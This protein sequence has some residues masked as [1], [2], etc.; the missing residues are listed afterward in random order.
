MT[1]DTMQAELP[2]RNR[3]GRGSVALIDAVAPLELSAE[4][5]G[6]RVLRAAAQGMIEAVFERACTVALS[7][8]GSIAL[9]A[10]SCGNHPRGVRLTCSPR[11][12]RIVRVGMRVRIS[13]ARIAIDEGAVAVLLQG[14][15]TWAPALRPGSLAAHAHAIASLSTTE[16]LLRERAVRSESAFLAVTLGADRSAGPL[17]KVVAEFLPRLCTAWAAADRLQVV[18]AVAR[19]IGL[20]PGLT[21]AG[22]DF[23][24]GWLA[25]MALTACSS[26]QREFLNLV[27]ADLEP[28]RSA[29]T[30]TSREYLDDARALLFSERLCDLAVAITACA[31]VE[32]LAE[33]V[34]AQLAV[35]A[36][37][38]ADAAAGLIAALHLS[39]HGVRAAHS[40]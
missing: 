3:A 27:C 15:Q 2:V 5:I 18:A 9:L 1:I 7:A 10:Q 6:C 19:V 30:P 26:E 20:G 24:I 34:D 36:S 21:P 22:D 31:P 13:P 37:S 29:T 23:V 25:G 11:L 28:L 17:G 4:S 14:A 12:D 39:M 33:R 16:R 32:T 35:G 38:G 40:S 8:G